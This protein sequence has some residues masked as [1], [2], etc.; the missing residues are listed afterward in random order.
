MS[1]E[2]E[3]NPN[4]WSPD[5][6]AL[7]FDRYNEKDH[8]DLWVLPLG[9]PQSAKPLVE[10]AAETWNGAVSPNGRWLAYQPDESGRY[11]VY[12]RDF[13][14]P[15]SKRQ[16]SRDGGTEPRW[17]ADGKELFYPSINGE[18][19]MVAAVETDSGFKAGMPGV[20]FEGFLRSATSDRCSYAVS[21][22]GQRFYM[23]KPSAKQARPTQINV[24][25]NWARELRK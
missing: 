23:I 9:S 21:P 1:A 19:L 12:V 7:V 3:L 11:E 2:P 6:K 24:V 5:G 13:P 20:L 8:R 22:D 25:V 15:G 17:S 10:G 16:V 4:S 14:G 18:R